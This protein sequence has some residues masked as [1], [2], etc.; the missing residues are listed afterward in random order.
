MKVSSTFWGKDRL[1]VFECRNLGQEFFSRN[2]F[3]PDANIVSR[4]HIVLVEAD[5]LLE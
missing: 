3:A 4:T 2:V 5:V 1:A